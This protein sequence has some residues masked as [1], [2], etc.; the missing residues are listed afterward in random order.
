MQ[1]YVIA[2]VPDGIA[3]EW[4]YRLNALREPGVALDVQFRAPSED[5]ARR[6]DPFKGDLGA[7]PV[8]SGG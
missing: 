4:L 7:A 6:L 2:A 3:L 5:I 1:V 8:W